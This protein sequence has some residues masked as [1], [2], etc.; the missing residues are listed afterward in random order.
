M[1][2]R[3]YLLISVML[4]MACL[5]VA[6]A[7]SASAE[8]KTI[9]V[10]FIKESDPTSTTT[11]LDKVAHA[12]GKITVTAGEKFTLP[13]TADNSYV[14]TEGYEL[15]W[16]TENGR[17]YKAGESVSFTEDTKL[18]RCAAKQVSTIE[19]LNSA[20]TSGSSHAIL[21]ADITTNKRISVMGQGY[22]VIVLNGHNI[23]IN[24][25]KNENSGNTLVIG[26]ARSAENFIGKGTITIDDLNN[27]VGECAVF[28]AHSHTYNGNRNKVL[29][30]A[31]V[32]LNAPEMHLAYDGE[33]GID[34]YPFIKIYGKVTVSHIL[35][36][37]NKS[38]WNVSPRV[39]IFDGAEVNLTEAFFVND[40]N[41]TSKYNNQSFRITISGGKFNLP[42]EASTLE[43][44]TTDLM[45]TVE[46]GGKTYSVLPINND[47]FDVFTIT[48]GSFNV[49]LPDEIIKNGYE[50]VFNEE[51]RMYDVVY[52]ACSAS[53]NGKH[54]FVKQETVAGYVPT[55]E[56]IGVSYYRC[57]CGS[58]YI[59]STPALGHDFSKITIK[60]PATTISS[61][62]KV[63]DCINC[64]DPEKT[65][66]EA[67][68]LDASAVEIT[69]TFKMND[70]SLKEVKVPLQNVYNLTT[71]GNTVTLTGVMSNIV[72]GEATYAKTNIVK[73]VIPLNVTVVAASAINGLSSLD[74]IIIEDGAKVTFSQAS[75]KN[76]SAL[77]TITAGEC[78]LIFK[79][80]TIETKSCA[81][82]TT[83][84]LRKANAT[85]EKTAFA[86]SNVKNLLLSSGRTYSFGEDAFRYSQLNEV[87]I[88]DNSTVTLGKKCF[89]ETTTIKYIYVGA[90]C[91][92]KKL[93][94][95]QSTF[96]GNSYLSKVV[97]MDLEYIGKWVLS[98]KAPGA[99]YGPLCDLYV[100]IHSETIGFSAT[101]AFNTRNGSYKVFLYMSAESY[102]GNPFAGDAA[103]N[104]PN[105]VLYQGI[106]HRYFEEDRDPSCT[107]PGSIGYSTDCPCGKLDQNATYTVTAYSGYTGDTNGGTIVIGDD[108]II[109]PLGHS[110]TYADDTIVE[111]IPS[112]CLNNSVTVYKCVNCDQTDSKEVEGTA[113]GHE[114]TA[115]WT[116]LISPTCITDG[117]RQKLCPDCG[118]TAVAEIIK[119]FGHTTAEEWTIVSEANCTMG[120]IREKRCTVCNLLVTKEESKPNGHVDGDW[121]HF[122]SATCTESGL[123]EMRCTVCKS[124]L[125]TI[126][127]KALGHEHDAI[128]GGA[129]VIALIYVNGLDKEGVK[130]VKC[131]RCDLRSEEIAAPIFIALG[132]SVG[133]NGDSLKAGFK[134]DA[135]AFEEYR[136]LNPEVEI[137]MIMVNANTVASTENLFVNGALNST[138]KGVQLSIES[139]IY[140]TWNVDV[141]GFVPA[142]ANSLELVIGVYIVNEEGNVTIMQYAD[143]D[144]YET[145]KTYGDMSV[146]AITFNQVRV[147]HGYEALVPQAAPVALGNDE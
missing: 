104:N 125:D 30:G 51:T 127:A 111:V 98:T 100:Y 52:V 103:S 138:A 41:N 146:N 33:G 39:Q 64:L 66:E 120:Q 13:T 135:H 109:A 77:K 48:G 14:G 20:T 84:D 16:Y 132:Y 31:D 72:V 83:L 89:A 136:L 15:V 118:E 82:F 29:I 121:A 25:K 86:S 116:V 129:T 141:T 69:M 6:W 46:S 93:G 119:A 102:T 70:G 61:G 115:D 26:A 147:G 106:A 21:T 110:F 37:G 38:T 80:Y 90:N 18:F 56:V 40:R 94:D 17:T 5:M 71:S 32:T 9:T 2:K 42:K 144:K 35:T 124:L 27:K 137:G 131:A 140:C 58:Q 50:C 101:G 67:Y 45:T 11:T 47:N 75:I 54:N 74:D 142:N 87:I 76:C 3:I 34:S 28:N 130:D 19:E 105:L 4:V 60:E 126:V 59:D 10:S 49:R 8:E 95:E 134:I 79:A 88:P 108:A 1:K 73:L 81:N 24:Y 78:S 65:Y 114:E 112:T 85:F 53:N 91:G 97:I 96:G 23:T 133:P 139:V 143:A 63:F 128:N 43:Y 117:V 62:I 107:L 22:S 7:F 123:D 122:A 113:N 55:C 44:W 68:T 99:N 57:A 12:D 36:V 145:T 92:V